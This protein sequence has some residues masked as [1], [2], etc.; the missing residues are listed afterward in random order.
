MKKKFKNL[1]LVV[2]KKKK[3]RKSKEVPEKNY[4]RSDLVSLYNAQVSTYNKT[5]EIQWKYNVII[6]GIFLFLIFIKHL[7]PELFNKPL[8]YILFL[9]GLLGH[10]IFLYIIQRSIA[11]SVKVMEV[12]LEH[13]NHYNQTKDINLR[14]RKFERQYVLELTDYLWI[15]FQ[16]V[17]SLFI[18]MVLVQI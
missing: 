9:T 18:L 7:H 8:T 14:N 16:L 10:Y 6:W 17:I 13:M 12:Y 11:I 3:S 15:A 2:Y 5:R 4:S 1:K